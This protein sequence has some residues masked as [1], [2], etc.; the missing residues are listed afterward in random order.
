LLRFLAMWACFTLMLS[1]TILM[2]LILMTGP[3]RIRAFVTG[4]Q[5]RIDNGI[6]G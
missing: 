4:E 1:A 6:L 5:R 3:K 2:T